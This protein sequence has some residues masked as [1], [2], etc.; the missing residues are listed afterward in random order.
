MGNLL[1]ILLVLF[2]ALI[3]VVKFTEK[4]AKP[5][6]SEQQ[7]K[8]SKIFMVLIFVMLVAAIVKYYVM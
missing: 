6:T 4:N 1:L 2:V 8:M 3:V 5:L 7:A